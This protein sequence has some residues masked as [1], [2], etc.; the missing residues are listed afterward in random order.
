V[1]KNSPRPR[2][3]LVL[4]HPGALRLM[5]F[6]ANQLSLGEAYIYDDYDIE[7]DIEEGFILAD[8]LLHLH[9]GFWEKLRFIHYLWSLPNAGP[10]FRERPHP[11]S[12]LIR[13]KKRNIQAVHYHYDQPNDFFSLW[14]D[15]GM[16][17]SCAYYA[18][19]EEDLEKAQ[20]RK[21]DYI[22]R[23]L[24]LQPGEDLLDIGC[25]WGGLVL[26]AAR[27]YGVR[28]HGITL[29][30]LQA[31]MATQRIHEAGL[32][33][34]CRVELID[35]RDLD[36]PNCYDKLVSVGMFEHVGAASLPE[37][38]SLA[39]RLL[40]PG[41]VFVN[42][43]ITCSLAH[44][45]LDG[46]S[47][48][49]HY[50]F[51]DGELLPI[52]DSLRIAEMTGFEVRDVESF[53]EH[54]ALTLRQWLRRLEQADKETERLTSEKTYRIWRLYLAGSAHG[55]RMGRLNVYQSLLV[56]PDH[57]HTSLPLTRA[58]WYKK[59]APANRSKASDGSKG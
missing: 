34:R 3:T 5:F 6:P 25:G 31:E 13:S 18:S 28:A 44:P 53:R 4:K 16:N 32:A 38:F 15:R 21:L 46:P 9:W 39:W 7:G 56:K 54:Y 43:G 26:H 22:C 19:A 29:S 12:G 57:G 51:P 42:D 33:E 17:Y 35:Y 49:R 59:T 50:V 47:F 36:K 2:C 27:H 14:L 11:I 1:W 8:V 23:K 24:R 55:F 48:V 10:S 52:V 37:Y 41:G 58:D 40:R 20:E 30:P 45:Q